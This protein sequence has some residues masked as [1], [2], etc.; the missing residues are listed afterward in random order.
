MTKRLLLLS[1]FFYPEPISTGRYNT[2]LVQALVKNGVSVD[3]ICFHPLYPN[4]RPRRSNRGLTGV[5]IVRGGAWM[6][7]PKNNLLR[8]A[9]LEACFL[10]H[11]MCHAGRIKKYS[12]VVAVLP[13]MLF[14]P[15]IRLFIGT[16]A[17]LTAIVHDL[18]GVMAAAGHSG[19]HGWVIGSI[20][21]LESMVL[22]Y[23]HRLMVLSSG[24]KAFLTETYH[25][26][27]SKISVHWPFATVDG[28]SVTQ[29]LLDLFDQNK[30]HIVYAGALGA[31][32]NPE[33]LIRFF[34]NLV[35]IRDDVVCHV[36]SGGLIF[37]VLKRDW[38]GVNDRLI[39]HNLIRDKD[40]PELYRRSDIQVIPERIGFSQGA[41][42][43]K[44]P[45]ILICGVPVLYIGQKD[46]DVWQV[47]QSTGAGLCTDT[48]QTDEL[49]KLIDQ[50]LLLERPPVLRDKLMSLF[51]SDAL[52]EEILS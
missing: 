15:L 14:L 12:R 24:M 43:S 11:V 26:S 6:R 7:F 47:I 20:R 45:N 31:K 50:L 27:P 35:E 8:R 3:V 4:W 51:N 46:S 19:Y 39:F 16:N 23:C 40:L 29:Q 10:F 1:P 30:K 9:L 34:A 52:I 48:W 13:P 5:R 37:E 25:V 32:Q 2:F 28:K 42:P 22:R 41:M 49:T 17:R 21:W 18:Q 36:F 44:L 38:C 33:G